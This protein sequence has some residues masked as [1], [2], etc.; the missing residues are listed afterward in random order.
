M[1]PEVD[2]K[3][4]ISRTGINNISTYPEV[5]VRITHIPTGASVTAT[6]ERSARKAHSVALESLQKLL[7]EEGAHEA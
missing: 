7:E 1:I 5:A 3:V 6:D 4:E 2:L